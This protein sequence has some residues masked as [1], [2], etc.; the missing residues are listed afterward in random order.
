MRKKSGI[1]LPLIV[2]VIAIGAFG[3][4][5]QKENTFEAEATPTPVLE[6]ISKVTEEEE[7]PPLIWETDFSSIEVI[8]ETQRL[9]SD[10]G[11]Y[12][13]SVDGDAGSMTQAGIAEYRRAAGL[14][15]GSEIDMDLLN[16]LRSAN[17]GLP[18]PTPTEKPVSVPIQQEPIR[19]ESIQQK[20]A[21]YVCITRTGSKY[22]SSDS[23]GQTITADTYWIT[24][25]EAIAKGY[26]ACSK[27]W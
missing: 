2:A 5:K 20:I 7:E 24:L 19:Q 11:F 9:L 15:G 23:C 14:P 16:T 25:D 12:T 27:C 17:H 8:M 3:N 18:T 13:G 26:T 22:H 1:L 21:Q 10:A 6:K 4:Q